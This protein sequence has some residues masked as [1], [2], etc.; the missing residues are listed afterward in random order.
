M[1]IGQAYDLTPPD[2]PE[3]DEGQS[4]WVYMDQFATIY[5]TGEEVPSEVDVDRVIRL[6]L[7]ETRTGRSYL[8]QRQV[9]GTYGWTE[10]L[11]WGEEVNIAAGELEIIDEQVFET[12]DYTYRVKSKSPAGLISESWN[13]LTIDSAG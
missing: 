8:V 1:K 9:R 6:K 12:E 3:W 4:G 7:M 2:P 10:I 11:G 5:T 13:S